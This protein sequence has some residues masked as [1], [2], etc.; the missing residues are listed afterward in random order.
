MDWI[1]HNRAR[2]IN[3]CAIPPSYITLTENEMAGIFKCPH[4]LE[5][6]CDMC[7]LPWHGSALYTTTTQATHGI[8]LYVVVFSCGLKRGGFTRIRQGHFTLAMRCNQ[9]IFFSV[10]AL[11]CLL[12][13]WDRLILLISVRV[14][15]WQLYYPITR[16]ATVKD[17]VN[18]SI[19]IPQQ[20][21]IGCVIVSDTFRFEVTLLHVPKYTQIKHTWSVSQRGW[22]LSHKVSPYFSN[23]KL[24]DNTDEYLPQWISYGFT[25]N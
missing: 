25:R 15:H 14:F 13:G 16:S 8:C 21:G 18:P 24:S 9:V 19:D 6:P 2:V 22:A 11:L 12:L 5:I 7:V 17:M 10:S 3:C 20:R 1:T 23:E 4:S